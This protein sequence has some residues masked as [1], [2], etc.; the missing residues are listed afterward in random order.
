[1][2]KSIVVAIAAMIVAGWI[3]TAVQWRE[4]CGMVL[5]GLSGTYCQARDTRG[6]KYYYN[7]DYKIYIK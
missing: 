4:D 3:Y 5:P 1:L 6:N 7:K 2:V